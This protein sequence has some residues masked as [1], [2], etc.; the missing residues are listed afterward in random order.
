MLSIRFYLSERF[1]LRFEDAGLEEIL[2]DE[3]AIKNNTIQDHTQKPASVEESS[4][5]EVA[6]DAFNSTSKKTAPSDRPARGNEP[7]GHVRTLAGDIAGD[8]FDADAINYRIL[9]RKIDDLLE[10]LKLDA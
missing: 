10:R 7:V 9:L 2:D 4:K 6:T 1:R 5:S 8:E 3:E